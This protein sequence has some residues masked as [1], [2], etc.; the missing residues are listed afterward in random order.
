MAGDCF[1][2]CQVTTTNMNRNV[3]GLPF[4]CSHCCG[5]FRPFFFQ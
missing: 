2:Q 1:P 4:G 5:N 3:Y